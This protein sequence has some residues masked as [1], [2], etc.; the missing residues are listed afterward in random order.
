MVYKPLL[1]FCFYTMKK[2]WFYYIKKNQ[3]TISELYFKLELLT[4]LLINSDGKTK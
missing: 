4:F 1:I 3:T 2:K